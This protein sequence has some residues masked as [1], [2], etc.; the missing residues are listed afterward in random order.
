MQKQE[1]VNRL[2]VVSGDDRQTSGD[3]VLRPTLHDFGEDIVDCVGAS[4]DAEPSF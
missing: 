4:R 1:E 3:G 2:A